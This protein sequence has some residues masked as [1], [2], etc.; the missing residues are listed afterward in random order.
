MAKKCILFSIFS[1]QIQT[2]EFLALFENGLLLMQEI[3]LESS[4]SLLKIDSST[5]LKVDVLNFYNALLRCIEIQHNAVLSVERQLFIRTLDKFICPL[6]SLA[7]F[8]FMIL[9]KELKIKM[10]FELCS[11]LK[12]SRG[13]FGF[14]SFLPLLH[15]EK[16]IS[17]Q[18]KKGRNSFG[19]L[20]STEGQ[21]NFSK[22]TS[23]PL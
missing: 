23:L 18:L 10:T 12:K 17:L 14:H 22:S 1:C 6:T 3:A 13:I 15:Q 16:L 5:C 19:I 9:F 2:F 7:N 8:A 20:F 11:P 21:K 4:R